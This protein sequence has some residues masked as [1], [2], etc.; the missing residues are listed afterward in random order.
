M[1]RSLLG[2]RAQFLRSLILALLDALTTFAALVILCPN[3]PFQEFLQVI[4]HAH[5]HH[6]NTKETHLSA[7]V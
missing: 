2:Y 6:H 3:H 5:H 4:I 1:G 7:L